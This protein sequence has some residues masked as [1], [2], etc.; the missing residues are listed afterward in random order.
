MWS[1]RLFWKLFLVCVGLNLALAAGF[2]FVV[3]RSQRAE[4][5]RQVE[6]RPQ[7][8]LID[9][10]LGGDVIVLERTIDVHI[11]SLK[12][13]FGELHEL[14]ETVRGIG[15]KFRDPSDGEL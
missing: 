2:L 4:I 13:K 5:N 9:A 8:E 3:M 12:N 1:S 11:R 7:P 10:A 15:Y 14:I 6:R